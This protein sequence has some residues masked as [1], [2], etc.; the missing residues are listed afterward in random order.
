M[1]AASASAKGESDPALSSAARSLELSM[2]AI[3]FAELARVGGR[4]A[5]T[6]LSLRNWS[7]ATFAGPGWGADGQGGPDGTGGA[8]AASATGATPA[9][10]GSKSPGSTCFTSALGFAA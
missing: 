6:V 1:R 8:A 2:P 7:A 3:F 9:A 5:A 4:S 10:G